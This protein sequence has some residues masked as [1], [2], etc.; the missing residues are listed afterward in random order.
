MERDWQMGFNLAKYKHIG[1]TTKQN[2]IQT[3]YN[4]YGHTL[5]KLQKPSS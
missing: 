1:I 3:S 4:I 5:K 2:V